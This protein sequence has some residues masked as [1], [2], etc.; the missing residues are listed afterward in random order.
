MKDKL[1]LCC[2][3]VD[4]ECAQVGSDDYYVQSRK[5]CRAFINQLR[6]LHG[7]EPFG[8]M[9]C[10]SAN[11][12]DFGTYYEVAVKYEDSIEEAVEYAFKLEDG[13]PE[14]WDEEA[15]IELGKS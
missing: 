3:P 6:R 14:K 10:I 12:H 8:A 7:E 5:E 11:P 13:L 15:L 4:E 2:S 9:L 1:E